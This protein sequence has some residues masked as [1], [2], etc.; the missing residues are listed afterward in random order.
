MSDTDQAIMRRCS[1]QLG[2]LHGCRFLHHPGRIEWKE[3]SG[4]IGAAS[5][6]SRSVVRPFP[7]NHRTIFRESPLLS[8]SC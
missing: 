5:S 4:R 1:G 6:T 7:F 8:S 2:R 3:A